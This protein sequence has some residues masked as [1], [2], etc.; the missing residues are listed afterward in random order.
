MNINA[1]LL[2]QTISFLL[3]VW[4]CKKFVWPMMMGPIMERQAKIADGLAA[5][6][7]GLKDQ[8]MAAENVEQVTRIDSLPSEAEQWQ[9]IQKHLN[10]R[11]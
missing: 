11:E 4:F 7:K 6:E 2:G 5:A 1:T 9:E 3:F 10:A 8:E